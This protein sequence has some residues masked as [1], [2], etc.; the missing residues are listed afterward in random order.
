MK[1]IATL[2]D[3][4]RIAHQA[5]MKDTRPTHLQRLDNN[6]NRHYYRFL[7]ECGQIY[8]P[9]V[10]VELG[11]WDGTSTFHFFDKDHTMQYIGVDITDEALTPE[12]IELMKLSKFTFL[13]CDALKAVKQI[14]E[15]LI[16]PI[17]LLFVD[18][19]HD[20]NHVTREI[21]LYDPLCARGCIQ[22]FDNIRF[23][24]GKEG[25]MGAFWDNLPGNKSEYPWLCTRGGGFGV[26]I[27]S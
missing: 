12:Y 25:S 10:I 22:C 20:Y 13:K 5:M 17:E 19:Y 27:K 15:M 18:D 4:D 11:I 21:E 1:K 16:S 26:R 6:P 2:P 7:W 9:K 23:E 3:L 24:K 8:E 14:Q